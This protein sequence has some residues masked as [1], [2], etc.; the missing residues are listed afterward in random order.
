M[1]RSRIFTSYL[2]ATTVLLTAAALAHGATTPRPNLQVTRASVPAHL[3]LGSVR[4]INVT[5]KNA[6]TASAAASSLKLTLSTTRRPGRTV[7]GSARVGV[8]APGATKVVSV[9]VTVPRSAAGG[10]TNVISCS[11]SAALLVESSELD[12][13]RVSPT[14]VM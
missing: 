9:R 4:S 14:H 11:D 13:C 8:I 2:A 7:L 6:G 3:E 12:N 10:Y 5:V 1:L